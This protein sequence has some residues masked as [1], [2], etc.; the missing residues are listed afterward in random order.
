M[1]AKLQ[2]VFREDPTLMEAKSV[3][4]MATMG[5]ARALGLEREIGSLEAGKKADIIVIDLNQPHLVPLYNLYS[6]LVY[7][8]RGADV[9]CVFINGELLV[10]GHLPT[11]A[12]ME[13]ICREVGN[14]KRSVLEFF[15]KG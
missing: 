15:K 2:K 5:G 6:H 4:N 12:D 8:A 3:V 7:A 1:A 9:E 13:G 14:L 10:E 11:Q